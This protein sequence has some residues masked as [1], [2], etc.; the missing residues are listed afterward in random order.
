M[1]NIG[2]IVPTRNLNDFNIE[3]ISKLIQKFD[4]DLIIEQPSPN[5]IEVH[6]RESP[7]HRYMIVQYW[8]G[9][10]MGWM[11]NFEEAIRQLESDG[12][13]DDAISLTW[14]KNSQPD[15]N[16]VIEYNYGQDPFGDDK[17]NLDFLIRDHFYGYIFDEGIHP[18]FI[19]PEYVRKK[20]KPT[21]L[22]K[23]GKFV[24]KFNNFLD[25]I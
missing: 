19:A 25:N 15:T 4:P 3:F 20:K 14:L 9:V 6:R 13:H 24:N 22:R 17:S 2:C 23:I 21:I 18:E 1:A 8:V 10:P 5:C 11:S 12:K 7:R 16:N